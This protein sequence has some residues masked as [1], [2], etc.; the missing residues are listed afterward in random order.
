MKSVYLDNGATS[1]PKAP[2]VAESMIYY[3]NNVGCNINRGAYDT[4]Y[5][6]ENVVFETRELICKLFNFDKPENVIFTKNITESL[7]I[8]IKGLIKK[9]DHV[10]VSSME[11]NAVMRPINSL[12]KKG[13]E[14]SRVMC[15]EFGRLK[16]EDIKKYIKENTKAV[17]MTHASNVCGTVLDLEEVGKICRERNIKFIIDSA[18]TAGFLDLDYKK[19]GAD[20][21]AFTGHK[22][23]LG[24]QGIGGFIINDNLVSEMESLIE[25]GTGSLSEYELQ[26]DYMPD[27][28]EAGTLNIPGIYGLNAAL[29]YLNKEGLEAIRQKELYLVKHFLEKINNIEGI[30]LVGKNDIK[31]RTGVV[32]IDFKNHDNAEISYRLYKEFGIKTRCGLHCAP[33][34]HKT[35]KTFPN[36]TV[37]FSFSH[38]NTVGEV[39]YTVDSI[40]RCLK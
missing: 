2:G 28:F 29:K 14:F 23:L 12:V 16:S 19:L 15:D 22:G 21:V 1:F 4:S 32:S 17:I 27:K 3:I 13:V 39:N 36:G 38:F 24:P 40:M 35:L 37:R 34:A 31:D 6:A 20:A 8:L 26:P 10:I 30:R 11:H 33:S 7:N 18:Q 9:G 5:E 25:G